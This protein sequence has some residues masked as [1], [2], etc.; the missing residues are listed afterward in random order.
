MSTRFKLAAVS[1]A[2]LA[3]GGLTGCSDGGGNGGKTTCGEFRALG[4]AAREKVV[5]KMMQD[6]GGVEVTDVAVRDLSI[7]T[8]FFCVDVD[9]GTAIEGVYTFGQ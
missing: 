6:R 4:T 5:A 9:A 8:D 2:I 3:L 7:R 1:A